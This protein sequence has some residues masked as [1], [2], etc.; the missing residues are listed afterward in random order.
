MKMFAIA[1]LLFCSLPTDAQSVSTLVGARAAGMGYTSSVLVDETALFNNV[2]AL[3]E[4]K[5]PASFF[6]YEA[7]PALL[8]NAVSSTSTELV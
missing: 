8:N 2:G 1:L 7:R 3:A 4:N 5:K 6:T